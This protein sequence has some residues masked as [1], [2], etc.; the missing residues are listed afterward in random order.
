MDRKAE[1]PD[2]S[3][4]LAELERLR[5]EVLAS[6]DNSERL[7]GEDMRLLARMVSGLDEERCERLLGAARERGWFALPLSA[8]EYPSL[9]SLCSL[10]DSLPGDTCRLTHAMRPGPFTRQ[11]HE[12]AMRA[13]RH[14]GDLALII[15]AGAGQLDKQG[16]LVLAEAARLELGGG[17]T[18]AALDDDHF[19]VIAP[20]ARQLKARALAERILDHFAATLPLSPLTP[21]PVAV[22]RAGIACFSPD[23]AYAE[24]AKIAEKLREQALSALAEAPPNQARLF[25]RDTRPMSEKSVLVQ[26][27]EKQ[28]LFFGSMEQ[29]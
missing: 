4:L 13:A 21:P 19:A 1:T 7:P 29:S 15:L 26:A 6:D 2:V 8:E 22:A 3:A 27:G 16:M 20:G 10:A 18:L 24:P 11:L 12:E 14:G 5:K 17:E 28:F 25:Q 9:Y 23:G